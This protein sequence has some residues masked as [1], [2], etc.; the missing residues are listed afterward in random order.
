MFPFLG[1]VSTDA[2]AGSVTLPPSCESLQNNMM[3]DGNGERYFHVCLKDHIKA[4]RQLLEDTGGTTPHK[5]LAHPQAPPKVGW[6]L[7]PTCPPKEIECPEARGRTFEEEGHMSTAGT[8]C[9]TEGQRCYITR[10]APLKHPSK[11]NA[12]SLTYLRGKCLYQIKRGKR[13]L[14]W[15]KTG[16][17]NRWIGR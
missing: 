16:I 7:Q 4:V 1:T 14:L 2:T 9:K 17:V 6:C 13:F 3:K 12:V 8:V 10:R 5:T 11:S 15:T